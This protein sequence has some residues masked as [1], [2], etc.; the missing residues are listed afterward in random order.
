MTDD[1]LKKMVGKAQEHFDEIDGRVSNA[2]SELS[3]CSAQIMRLG[4]L[5]E[6]IKSELEC[7]V[8]TLD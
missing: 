4:N 7:R 2:D 5:L 3:F 1:E 8:D 6:E